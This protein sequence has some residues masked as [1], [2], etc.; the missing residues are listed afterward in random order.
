[1]IPSNSTPELLQR[2]TP[3]QNNYLP[4][5]KK[6]LQEYLEKKPIKTKPSASTK[7]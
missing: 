4:K 2:N 7:R 5:K 3:T 1:M 6:N